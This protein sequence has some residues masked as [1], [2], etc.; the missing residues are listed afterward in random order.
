[1]TRVVVHIGRLVLTGF[2]HGDRVGI[3]EGLRH[4]LSRALAEP[5]ALH[6]LQTLGHVRSVQVRDS[7]IQPRSTSQRIGAAVA[8]GVRRGLHK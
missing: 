8:G 5:Q 6:R 4:E 2:A 3:A 7:Q 1:M